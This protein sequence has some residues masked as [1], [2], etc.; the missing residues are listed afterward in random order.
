MNNCTRKTFILAAASALVAGCTSVPNF[1]FAE[2]K[3]KFIDTELGQMIAKGIEDELMMHANAKASEEEVEHAAKDVDSWLDHMKVNGY[4]ESYKIIEISHVK[5]L[6]LK[7]KVA[8][9]PLD[10]E[11]IILEYLVDFKA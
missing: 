8:I 7:F 3:Q 9:K 5:E 2:S 4:I 10:R 6:S 11:Y 1:G